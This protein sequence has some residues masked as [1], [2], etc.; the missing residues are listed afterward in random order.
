MFKLNYFWIL[1][2]NIFDYSIIVKIYNVLNNKD[3]REK[4]NI[5]NYGLGIGGDVKSDECLIF[6]LKKYI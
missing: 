6:N 1:N 2:E 5:L 4:W 3:K